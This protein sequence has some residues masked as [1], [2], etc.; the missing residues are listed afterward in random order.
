MVNKEYEYIRGNTALNPKRKYDEVKR[1]KERENL[2]RQ[3]REQQRRERNAK[4]SV[5]KNILQVASIA[6]VL[7]VLTIARDGKVFKMQNDLTNVKSEIKT[8][9]AEGEALRVNLLKYSSLGD[10]KS[11]AT[12]AGMKI[13]QIDDTIT[14]NI[15]KDFFANIR[16]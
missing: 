12:E 6:L 8:V 15:T 10:V 5:V 2:E 3:R 1:R 4:K 9:T 11:A 14:V 16:E 13:P 7:G